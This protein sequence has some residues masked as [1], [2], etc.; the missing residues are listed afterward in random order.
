LKG[1]QGLLERPDGE[2]FP[3]LA[4]PTPLFD[5]EKTLIGAVNVLLDMK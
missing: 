3:Y 1:V 5:G 2:R 4:Y